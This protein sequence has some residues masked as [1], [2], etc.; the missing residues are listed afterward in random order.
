MGLKHPQSNLQKIFFPEVSKMSAE[1]APYAE[2]I[3]GGI[4]SF[5]GHFLIYY[6]IMTNNYDLKPLLRSMSA[7]RSRNCPLGH[8]L[9]VLI[10]HMS[11]RRLKTRLAPWVDHY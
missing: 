5:L 9:C 1:I 6:V 11:F 7:R 2:N 8:I 10:V 3:E 4:D